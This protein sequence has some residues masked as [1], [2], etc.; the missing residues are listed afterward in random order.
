MRP[1][2]AILWSYLV[3]T[4]ISCGLFIPL[5]KHRSYIRHAAGNMAEGSNL[6]KSLSNA[7]TCSST[8][9]SPG[10]GL[11][12]AEEQSDAAYA[13]IINTSMDQR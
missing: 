1:P 8:E 11:L 2:C 5:L 6:K 9:V 10:A 7:R 4:A 12:T 3:C 13:D